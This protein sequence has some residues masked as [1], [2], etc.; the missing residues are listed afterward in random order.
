MEPNRLALPSG[1][2][3]PPSSSSEKPRNGYRLASPSGTGLHRQAVPLGN[4]Q[5]TQIGLSRLA[6]MYSPPGSFWKISRN[7]KFTIK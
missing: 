2:S 1:N 7:Q 6:V 3:S 5:N 4:P